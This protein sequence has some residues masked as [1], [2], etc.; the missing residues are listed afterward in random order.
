MYV[1][2][3]QGGGQIVCIYFIFLFVC[4]KSNIQ[5]KSFNLLRPPSHPGNY[6]LLNVFLAIAVDNLSDPESADSEP[7]EVGG[8]R[9]GGEVRK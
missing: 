4:G 8:G 2:F 5:P 3:P 7:P 6:I 1:N 9:R